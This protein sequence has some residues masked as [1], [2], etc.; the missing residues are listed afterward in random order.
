MQSGN[1]KVSN[2]VMGLGC[3]HKNAKDKL[4]NLNKYGENM[5]LYKVTPSVS[6]F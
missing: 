3:S 6:P 5:K 4:C 2:I 1:K